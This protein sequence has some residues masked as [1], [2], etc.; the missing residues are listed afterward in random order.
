VSSKQLPGETLEDLLGIARALR[1]VRE[2]HGARRTELQRIT[3]VTG[4]LVS[5]LELSKTKPHTLE[6]RAAWLKAEQ[7][8][9]ALIALLLVH[10]EITKRLVG[11]CAERLRA[12]AK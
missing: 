5:A 7:A 10:D 6:H 2:N 11:A 1:I 3:E 4:W 9:A 8:T 12:R